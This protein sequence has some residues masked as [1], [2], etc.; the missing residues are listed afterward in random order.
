MYDAISNPE[1]IH[2]VY[3]QTETVS[4]F[5]YFA[6]IMLVWFSLSRRAFGLLDFISML[7]NLCRSLKTTRV[8]I[9]LIQKLKVTCFLWRPGATKP[10]LI[11]PW[12][13]NH[14]N[15]ESVLSIQ[16]G[17]LAHIHWIFKDYSQ[18]HLD[19]HFNLSFFFPKWTPKRQRILLPLHCSST[20]PGRRRGRNCSLIRNENSD[21]K[22]KRRKYIS[23]M[24]FWRNPGNCLQNKIIVMFV[25]KVK[26]MMNDEYI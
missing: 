22:T 7:N 17:K 12:I 2:R 1:N 26:S 10:W 24:L 18:S 9:F 4:Y 15:V 5:S 11:F 25:H 13:R 19:I 6:L 14:L 3:H 16:I 20:K 8:A 21:A 23:Q